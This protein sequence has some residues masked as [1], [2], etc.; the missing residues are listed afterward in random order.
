[1]TECIICC[2]SYD[3][4]VKCL[5]CSN[6]TC[7]SCYEKC[8]KCPFCNNEKFGK[9]T[10]TSFNNSISTSIIEDDIVVALRLQ[11]QDWN[12]DDMTR[13]INMTPLTVPI[14]PPIR[15]IIEL[16]G[17]GRVYVIDIG[18]CILRFTPRSIIMNTPIHNYRFNTN[19]TLSTRHFG[20]IRVDYDNITRSITIYYR[21]N[22]TI[23]RL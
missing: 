3:K 1:M 9:K 11:L 18:E 19:D 14:L 8:H 7:E 22:T 13:N 20:A 17:G 5:D 15:R 4:F 12:I 21:G 23:I 16:P 6:G 2:E 10:Q